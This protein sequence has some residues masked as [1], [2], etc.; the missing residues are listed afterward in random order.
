MNYE[1]LPL[2]GLCIVQMAL[3]D[4]LCGY[5]TRLQLFFVIKP[6]MIMDKP[7]FTLTLV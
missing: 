4:I 1:L 6:G 7:R 3:A 5:I 2:V